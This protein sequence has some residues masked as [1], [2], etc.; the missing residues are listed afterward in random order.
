MSVYSDKYTWLPLLL[1]LLF[2]FFYKVPWKEGLLLIVCSILLGFLCDFVSSEYIKPFFGRL[3]PSHHPDFKD[4]V[5]VVL[6]RRG[7]SF[8]FIS[9]HAANG[10]GIAVL[11]SLL[12][13]YWPFTI[14]IY[15]WVIVTCYSRIYLGVHFITDIVGGFVWGTIAG[16]VVYGLYYLFRWKVF[17]IPRNQLSQPVLSPQKAQISILAI[18]LTVVYITIRGLF[19]QITA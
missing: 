10:F 2:I 3:R 5:D 8:G 7:G 12:F 13:R 18:L 6:G 11:T 1:V 15:S 14:T 9:N 4:M 16:L 19:F 17:H